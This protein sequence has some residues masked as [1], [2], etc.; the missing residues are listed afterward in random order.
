[1]LTGREPHLPNEEDGAS[2]IHGCAQAELDPLDEAWEEVSGI[3]LAISDE[4]RVIGIK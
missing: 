1:M 4:I 2:H 3:L